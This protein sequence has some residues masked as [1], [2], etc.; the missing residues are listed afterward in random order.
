VSQMRRAS[1]SVCA[2]LSE[3]SSRHSA[4]DQAHFTSLAFSSLL[5]L[6]NHS[7]IAN[8]LKM[9]TDSELVNIRKSTQQLSIRLSNLRAAQL[10]R[11][12]TA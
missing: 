6:L 4:K 8:D 1:I 12:K 2:N 3:G 11:D 10:K 5:E 9:V 7:I